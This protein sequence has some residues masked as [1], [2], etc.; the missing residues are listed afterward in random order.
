MISEV[1]VPDCTDNIWT[2]DVITSCWASSVTVSTNQDTKWPWEEFHT[3][4]SI[5]RFT[6]EEQFGLTLPVILGEDGELP[7]Y[8]LQEE[9][10]NS[11]YQCDDVEHGRSNT[12][13][14]T[15]DLYDTDGVWVEC[16]ALGADAK[17]SADCFN[18]NDW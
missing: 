8:N 9:N 15:F 12:M 17:A 10:V 2:Y 7:D 16:V 11:L 1:S 6:L 3:L 14:W 4:D 5:E 13:T 18:A